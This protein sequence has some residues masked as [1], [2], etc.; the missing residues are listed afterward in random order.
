M[1]STGFMFTIAQIA[2]G[3]A[4]FSAVIVTLNAK[5]IREVGRQQTVLIF[6]Y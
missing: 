4:G 6:D 5:P 2:V 3:L 1:Q